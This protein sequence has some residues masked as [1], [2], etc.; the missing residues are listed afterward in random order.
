MPTSPST[1]TP[2]RVS[3]PGRTTTR[4]RRCSGWSAA[5]TTTSTP[6][7]T[8]ST[9]D[10]DAMTEPQRDLPPGLREQLDLPHAGLVT[11]GQRPFLSE[12]EQ[13]DTWRPDVAIVGAP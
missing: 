12:P 13:L 5:R 9:S 3:C 8:S 2:S 11:F 6:S 10:R 7:S 4:M 1:D